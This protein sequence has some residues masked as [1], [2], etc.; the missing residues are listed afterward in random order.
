MT[1]YNELRRLF[2]EFLSRSRDWDLICRK[3]P[4]KF[5][6]ALAAH[7][8]APGEQYV[9]LYR[10]NEQEDDYVPATWRDIEHDENG[11]WSFTIGVKLEAEEGSGPKGYLTLHC[12]FTAH[13]DKKYTLEYTQLAATHEIDLNA[14][15]PFQA[16]CEAVTAHIV[17]YLA[18]D[19]YALTGA[20]RKQGFGFIDFS[21]ASPRPV[22]KD[23]N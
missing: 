22:S 13:S 8:G 3:F 11:R 18:D 10:L 15:R 23:E 16:A 4:G 17:Q 19:P 12:H 6:R 7:L 5:V 2:A 14:D 1:D 9:Q 20:N 21:D